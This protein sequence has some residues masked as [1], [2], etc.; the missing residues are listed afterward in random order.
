MS[1][2]LEWG[3]FTA[4]DDPAAAKDSR[5]EKYFA[6]PAPRPR[7]PDKRVPADCA[8]AASSRLCL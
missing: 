3:V 7:Q 4:H 8:L 5:P 2:L 1:G 6:P